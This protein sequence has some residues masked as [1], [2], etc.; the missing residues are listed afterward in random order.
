MIENGG[1]GRGLT[2]GV[3]LSNE[4]AAFMKLGQSE[5]V[6]GNSMLDA[7]PPQ[8]T[9]LAGGQVEGPLLGIAAQGG[10]TFLL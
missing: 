5:I 7:T 4:D 3:T 1:L 10:D 6:G 8:M 2:F 9:V